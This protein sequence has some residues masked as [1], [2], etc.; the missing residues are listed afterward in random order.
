MDNSLENFYNYAFTNHGIPRDLVCNV[1]NQANGWHS[2]KESA[3]FV[4][5]TVVRNAVYKLSLPEECRAFVTNNFT[6]I[7]TVYA[8]NGV[9]EN[10]WEAQF[11]FNVAIFIISL[12]A[13]KYLEFESHLRRS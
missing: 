6:D 12:V 11:Y 4:E 1:V 10:M 8:K 5:E 9:T 13:N 2:F 3:P 7:L